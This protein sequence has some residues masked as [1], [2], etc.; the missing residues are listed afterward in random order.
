[1]KAIPGGQYGLVTDQGIRRIDEPLTLCRRSA[2]RFTAGSSPSRRSSIRG[3]L[4]PVRK[5]VKISG[6]MVEDAVAR[7]PETGGPL[8]P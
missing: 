2:S 3:R 5:L 6:D 7:G 8:R 4:R 1:M